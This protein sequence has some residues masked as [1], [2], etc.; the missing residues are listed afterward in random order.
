MKANYR[1][2]EMELMMEKFQ[3]DRKKVPSPTREEIINIA[4]K[5]SRLT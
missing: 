3:A 4:V 2:L 5:A 1:D